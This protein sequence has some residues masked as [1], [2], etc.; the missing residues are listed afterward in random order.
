MDNNELFKRLRYA[1]QIDDSTAT[2]ILKQ[3]GL[4]ATKEQVSSWR[5]ND[6]HAD[7]Q[8]CPNEVI[9]AF[10]AGFIV[11]KRGVQAGKPVP[12]PSTS[13]I[14][15][16][17]VLKMMK[18]AL[19][20]RSEDLEQIIVAGGAKLTASEISALLRK[21]GSRNYRQCGDQVLRQFI[22]GVAQTQRDKEPSPIWAEALKK[23][24]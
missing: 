20:L 2:R 4:K 11:E 24:K 7:Y 17:S 18:I 6:D 19:E 9:S 5:L 14:E 8:G 22:N 12:E 15:N 13:Y 3:G 10:L 1:L 21:P 16:N 23:K